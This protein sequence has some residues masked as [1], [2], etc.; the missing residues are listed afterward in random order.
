ME[1]QVPFNDLRRYATVVA[2]DLEE[3]ARRVI[4]SGWYLLG[5]ETAALEDELTTFTGVRG[6]VTVAN[7]TDALEIALRAVGV[8]A[9]DEVVLAANAGGYATTAT[10]AIGAVPV[11]ADVDPASLLIDPSAVASS[12]SP[13]TTAVVVTHL[14]GNVVDVGAVRRAVGSEIA[15]IEDVAQAHGASFDGRRAGAMGDA[16]TYSFYPTKNLGA[17]GDGGAVLSDDADVL[18]RA[19][20]LRQYGWTSRYHATIAGGRNSRLDEI[21]AGFLRVLLPDVV[22]RN[23]RRGAIRARYLDALDGRVS[24]VPTGAGVVPATHLCVVRVP[25]RD[26]VAAALAE[27]GV[28]T[29]V[30]FPIP[31]HRQPAL[32]GLAHRAGPLVETERACA[33]VLSLPCFPE[34]RDDE[35]DQVIAAVDKVT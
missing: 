25:E 17:L 5:P 18:E 22:G 28:A 3:A 15:V 6:C 1:D 9:G 29:A 16:S 31:D 20:A 23:E 26:A 2:D 12:V 10:L 4:R 27:L 19:R 21:Q 24:F 34:L 35:I 13:S 33:E 32:A 8:G 7:G 14:Y 11:F 30:H